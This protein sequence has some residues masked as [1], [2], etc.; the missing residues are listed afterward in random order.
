M[1]LSQQELGFLFL[2]SPPIGTTNDIE[3]KGTEIEVNVNPTH[4]WTVSGSVTDTQAVDLNVSKSLADWIAQRMPIWTTI[5]DPTW[6]TDPVLWSAATIAAD[7]TAGG[8][9]NHLWW[10][11]HYGAT[12]QSPSENFQAFVGAPYG[13]IKAQEGKS[14]PQVRR[15]AFRASTAYQLAGLFNDNQ[16]L[17]H[18]TVGGALRWEDKGAIGYYGVQS[19]PAIITDLDPN[20]PIY[21]KAHYYVD[22]FVNYKTKL[23]R[24]KI[25]VTFALNV[26][27]LGQKVGLQPV[28]AF[29]DGSI[30]TYRI[31]DPQQFIFT[32]TFDF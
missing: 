28:G 3:S 29:P 31:I 27:N 24:D 15:Y 11:H 32:T 30:S 19:L 5:V 16:W 26:T 17:K 18:V 22:A 12:G 10:L 1:G 13:I 14:N 8:N 23:W 4:F 2:P 21:D 9:P 20:R 7:N 25:G 6:N